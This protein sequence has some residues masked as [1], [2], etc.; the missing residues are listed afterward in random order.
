MQK[1]SKKAEMVDELELSR[2]NDERGAENLS[3][4]EAD[5]NNDGWQSILADNGSNDAVT[6]ATWR[7]RR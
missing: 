7:S 6:E 4:L 5:N 3:L 1:K 2:V